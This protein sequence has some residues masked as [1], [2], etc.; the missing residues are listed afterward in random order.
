MSNLQYPENRFCPLCGKML[1]G[2]ANKETVRGIIRCF[3][4]CQNVKHRLPYV[5]E[6]NTSQTSG[7]HKIQIGRA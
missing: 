3:R 4:L 7:E 1:E 5:V 2:N 6:E